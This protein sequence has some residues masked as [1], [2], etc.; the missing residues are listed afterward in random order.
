[1]YGNR[2]VADVQFWA[3]W[4]LEQAE[5][6]IGHLYPVGKDGKSVVAYL[7]ARTAPCSNPVCRAEIPLLRSLLV[8][9]KDRKRVA[10]T[11]KTQGKEIAFAIAKGK[12]IKETD[13]TMIEKGRGSVRCPICHQTT[14]VD[15]LRR[16][17]LEGKMGER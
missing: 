3:K 4:A 13:G 2:L 10:L 16:A 15:D 9:N 1:R 17:G 14:P 6:K 7:W 11:M 5:K 12:D 8:C